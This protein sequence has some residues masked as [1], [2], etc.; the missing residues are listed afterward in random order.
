MEG[1]RAYN[2][3]TFHLHTRVRN[4]LSIF[5]GLYVSPL[6][7]PQNNPNSPLL[8]LLKHY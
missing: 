8:H 1:K 5:N 6:T 3:A 7:K 4:D 2:P